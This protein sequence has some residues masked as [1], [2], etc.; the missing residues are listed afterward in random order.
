[1]SKIIF[2]ILIL[3]QIALVDFLRS[4]N[5]VPDKIIG[6]SVG[7]ISCA[8]ADKCF[9]QE[10]AIQCA[11][12]RAIALQEGACVKGA[13]ASIGLPASQLEN[14]LPSGTYVACHNAPDNST[15]SGSPEQISTLVEEFKA[16]GTFAK[17]INS[18]GYAFHSPLIHCASNFLLEKLRNLLP[19]PKERSGKW[20]STAFR[21]DELV[22]RD[23]KLASAEY[24]VHNLMSPVLFQ[25]GLAEL[26]GNFVFLE[27]APKP[28][29]Q[30]LLRRSIS[31][32]SVAM[33]LPD[34]DKEVGGAAIHKSVGKL[35]LN[36]L[37]PSFSNLCQA[38]AK[39]PVEVETP[40]LSSLIQWDHTTSWN[41]Q[42]EVR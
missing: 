16:S 31:P 25:E 22:T 32:S 40:S 14:S 15:I 35:F 29:L 42:T 26:K 34:D 21:Q 11:Y 23:A 24:F 6:H 18:S 20:I 12:W 17:I 13:M 1:M 10:E 28:I 3:Q 7:E 8:Y 37:L 19:E 9:S 4:I 27:I 41:V 38:A 30:P 5:I 39:L 33:T 2:G 36:G